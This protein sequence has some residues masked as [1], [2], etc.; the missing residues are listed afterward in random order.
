LVAPVTI[1]TLP[2]SLTGCPLRHTAGDI[3]APSGSTLAAVAIKRLTFVRR[4]PDVVPD[5]FAGQ[6]RDRAVR[7]QESA[8]AA[9]KVNRL[10]H[11]IVRPGRTDRPHHGVAVAWFDDDANLAAYDDHAASQAGDP[12]PVEESTVV[13]ALVEERTVFGQPLLDRWWRERNG[14][15]RLLLLGVIERKPDLSREEFRDYWW[16]QHRPLANRMLPSAVQPSIYVHD[17]ARPGEPCPWDGVGEFYDTSVDIA[18]RRTQ[19]AATGA[20]AALVADEEKFLVRDTRYAL[21]TD[22]EVVVAGR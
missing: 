19:W 22:A 4:D 2:S 9:A 21:I 15:S 16:D 11:C 20:A 6:W 5:A 14:R 3:A 10:V 8:P 13:H 12:A 1:A 18:R 7:L 17:Y